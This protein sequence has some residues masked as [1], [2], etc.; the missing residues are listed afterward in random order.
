MAH[1]VRAD[2]VAK[3][4]LFNSKF[5]R[6]KKI[7]SQPGFA[8]KYAILSLVILGATTI[9]WAF[10]GA[11][12][13]QGNADQLVNSLLF[14]RLSTFREALLPGQHSFLIK[15]PLFFLIKLLGYSAITFITVT[16]ATALATVAFLVVLLYRIERR[17]LIFGT[18]CLA[19]ASVLLLIPAQ[20]YTGVMLPVNMAMLTTRNLE[21]VLYIASLVLLVRSPRIK[22][23]GFWL[24][25]VFLTLLIASDKLF[26][27][28]S[29]GGALLA[30]V[31]YALRQRQGLVNLS[32][33]WLTLSV[34]SILGAFG[35]LWL[36]NA[37][38]VTHIANQPA[39]GP[40]GLVH[41]ERS[42]ALGFIYGF[43]GLMT[44]FGANLAYD[45]SV[46]KNIPG[47]IYTH[48]LGTGG[49]AFM[50]NG[51]IFVV[52]VVIVYRLI[53]S[54]L[55]G[56][57]PQKANLDNATKLSILLI[58][59]T[60]AAFIVFAASNHYYAAD[61]R[62]LTIALFAVF[63]SAAVFSRHRYWH[64]EKTVLVGL[65]ITIGILFGLTAA[66]HSYNTDKAALAEVNRRNISISQALAQHPV[67]VLAG[68]YWRVTPTRLIAG[69]RFN[70][71]PL[72]G[73]TRAQD[74]LSSKSWQPDLNDHS[75]AYLLS[76]DQSLTNYP[77]C[78]LDLVV[79]SY[80]RPN[81]SILIAGSLEHPKE[82]VLFYDN[83][84]HK[85]APTIKPPKQGTATVV[86]TTLDILPNTTCDA[87]TILNVVAHQDD[88]LLFMN[89]DLAHDIKAGH[90]VRTIYM[91]AGDAGDN[92]F[93]WLG[94]EQG[95][96]AAYDYIDG[97]DKD[98]WVQR[99]VKLSAKAFIS[100]ANPR[101]NSKVSLIFMRLPDGGIHG[102]GFKASHYESLERLNA[103]AIS[104]V[105]S[106]DGS[107]V[108]TSSE[109]T[110]A[111]TALM[112]VY[113]PSGVHM[114]STSFLGV[115]GKSKYPDHSDHTAAGRY[116]QRA[117][118]QFEGFHETP[119]KFYLGYPI[120]ELPENVGGKDLEEK[121]KTF[122]NYGKFDKS[123]CQT[124]KECENTPTYSAYL[125]HQYQ[126]SY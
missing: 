67:S 34:V 65:I 45:S 69:N 84:I 30:F 31:V 48:L 66:L 43:L 105:H 13:Q 113:R 99:I 106:I 96:E 112:R 86:P 39:V 107:S 77:S 64:P 57:K 23:W 94:R 42:L 100:I 6:V 9:L 114:Q 38:G 74:I 71:M 24:A 53:V 123:V 109:L 56:G 55:A 78:T 12:L 121:E 102:T 16:V 104:Q 117:Y 95:S 116:A 126:N 63:I 5:K 17:P 92:K 19:L 8:K 49:I 18:L 1:K 21:Y 76:L 32:A 82:L 93:Y 98:I 36:L 60:L 2:S 72:T 28:L 10:L 81:A 22:S 26:L 41:N 7:V 75:F 115:D 37:V 101:G 110:A 25:I 35:L 125:R 52:G 70:V 79:N 29:L 61:A 51:I 122:L 80:G 33:K 88:D 11:K 103:G 118:N 58:W 108:Y 111:L 14:E 15:W 3:Y 90:C 44:N 47:Q 124:L 91:T 68:D 40:F 87:P 50:L 97:P 62:Y 73:C 120:H 4:R 59:T 83:G 46:L 89:P 119:I 27:T 54:S 85:S 20:P